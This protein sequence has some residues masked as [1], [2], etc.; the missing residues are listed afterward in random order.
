MQEDIITFWFHWFYYKHLKL[1]IA[2]HVKSWLDFR[3]SERLKRVSYKTNISFDLVTTTKQYENFKYFPTCM[4][5]FHVVIKSDVNFPLF[6]TLT[7]C[8]LWIVEKREVLYYFSSSGCIHRFIREG[9][10]L[11]Y[12]TECMSQCVSVN[13]SCEKSIF[14]VD[15][16][17]FIS[18]FTSLVPW[19][20]KISEFFG[21]FQC[22]CAGNNVVD[23]M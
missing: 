4:W 20:M 5:N 3:S 21:L 19:I 16:K 12:N 22:Y 8:S 23:A 14:L 15:M 9:I 13:I 7:K 6:S 18:H 1:I 2:T 10:S 11:V 17:N